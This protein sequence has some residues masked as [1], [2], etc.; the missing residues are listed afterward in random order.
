MSEYCFYPFFF[1]NIW[2]RVKTLFRYFDNSGTIELVCVKKNV[3]VSCATPVG[4]APYSLYAVLAD[5]ERFTGIVD[6]IPA[7]RGVQRLQ[8][9]EE[10]EK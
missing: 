2:K 9:L 4:P 3:P 8:R 1:Y 10:R 6:G 5:R 7:Y